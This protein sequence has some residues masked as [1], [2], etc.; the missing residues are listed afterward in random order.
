VRR[1]FAPF[2]ALSLVAAALCS[3]PAAHVN[4][5]DIDTDADADAPLLW[6]LRDDLGMTG[7]T[8]GCGTGLSRGGRHDPGA[9]RGHGSGAVRVLAVS[10]PAGGGRA[11]P[12]EPSR[13]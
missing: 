5:R 2:M 13:R 6:V 8:F 4:G 3:A 9:P 1:E 10:R 11:P 12:R 7:M